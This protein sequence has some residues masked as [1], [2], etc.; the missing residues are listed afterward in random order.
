[1]KNEFCHIELTTDD[2][3]KA[4]EFYGGLF[5]WKFEDVD[6]G[7]Q[8]YTMINPGAGPGGGIMKKP[9]PDAPTAWVSYVMVEKVD[10]TLKMAAKLGGKVIVPKT[11]IPN[12]GSFGIILDPT[13]GCLG[14]WE[15]QAQAPAKG[16]K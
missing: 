8:T 3:G 6:M 12:M 15:T 1:M 16:K 13:G 10:A 7:G 14:V 9:M 4:K 11:A 2:V 5:S